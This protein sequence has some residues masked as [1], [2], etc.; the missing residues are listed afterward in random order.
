MDE[1][2]LITL[3]SITGAKLG[4]AKLTVMIADIDDIPNTMLYFTK[5]GYSAPV[6][7]ELTSDK[8]G[9]LLVADTNNWN[10]SLNYRPIIS[11]DDDS[12]EYTFVPDGANEWTIVITKEQKL[13]QNIYDEYM[14][15]NGKWE[16]IGD[17]DTTVDL[18]GYA[19]EA[20]VDE[21]V[22]NKANISDVNAIFSNKMNKEVDLAD[23]DAEENPVAKITIDGTD[24]IDI[25]NA[26]A[27]TSNVIAKNADITESGLMITI[28][29]EQY[30]LSW[31]LNKINTDVTALKAAAANHLTKEIVTELP[32]ENI[33]TNRI[34][35]KPKN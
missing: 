31:L 5:D 1:Q 28:D 25:I 9:E 24:I 4:T 8:A 14:F 27:N 19:T 13:T 2:V 18:A 21:A 30:S 7:F 11:C 26:K 32:T 17:T 6:E 20:Y 16:L 23:V 29:E 3:D 15:V 33:D 10:D 34:Y 22:A 35:I 12:V